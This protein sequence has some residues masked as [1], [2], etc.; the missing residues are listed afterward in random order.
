[1]ESARYG[2]GFR[3]AEL[4]LWGHTEHKVSLDASFLI[5]VVLS[6][7]TRTH[8]LRPPLPHLYNVGEDNAYILEQL[9]K[10]KNGMWKHTERSAHPVPRSDF[11]LREVR[12][13]YNAVASMKAMISIPASDTYR[14]TQEDSPVLMSVFQRSRI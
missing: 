6:V 2:C 9:G 5:L 3:A 1:M 7:V 14:D 4:R 8:F 13:P 10:Q 12:P 11:L